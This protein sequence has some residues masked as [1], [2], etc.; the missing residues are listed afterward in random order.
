MKINGKLAC[1]VPVVGGIGIAVAGES[2]YNKT[3]LGQNMPW[4]VSEKKAKEL[5]QAQGIDPLLVEA[6]HA[7][8]MFGWN[9]KGALYKGQR[10][11]KP[12]L[13]VKNL[14]KVGEGVRALEISFQ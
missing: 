14:G 2:G 13:T 11:D 1:Y 9:V 12:V 3:D 8:S 5:N 10:L 7:G 6:L 4:N